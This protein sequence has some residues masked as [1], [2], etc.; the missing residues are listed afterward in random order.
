MNGNEFDRKS[1]ASPD[2]LF[3]LTATRSELEDLAKALEDS[4]ARW[5][6]MVDTKYGDTVPEKYRNEAKTWVSPNR[7]FLK[8]IDK[9]LE[10]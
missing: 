7:K 5:D 8:D 10:G 9:I 2:D 4:I 1:F 6:E 3:I